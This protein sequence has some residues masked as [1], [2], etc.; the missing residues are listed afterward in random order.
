MLSDLKTQVK[1]FY[2]SK[3]PIPP[4]VADFLILTKTSLQVGIYPMLSDT[5]VLL[6][7]TLCMQCSRYISCLRFEIEK[8][9]LEAF[10]THKQVNI[11]RSFSNMMTIL[12]DLQ[13]VFS[14]P[15]FLMF[16]THYCACSTL[17]GWF[18][19]G[20]ISSVSKILQIL[21]YFSNSSVC[22]IACLWVPGKLPI[23]I[24]KMKEAF[25]S[26][27]RYRW[28][29]LGVMEENVFEKAF[30]EQHTFVLTG[31][32]FIEFKQSSI[33]AVVGTILSYTL[34]LVTRS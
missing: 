33:L 12:K 30:G 18:V 22:L 5:F 26:K 34:V 13:K 2:G 15:S 7:C 16:A 32:R 24:D 21:F 17:L 27:Y 10:D 4:A 6:F 19:L 8:C 14:L 23:E 29:H 11:A 3:P 31:V 28:F 20:E 9:T 25:R 1:N